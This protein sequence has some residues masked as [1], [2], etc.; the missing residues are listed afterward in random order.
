MA[1]MK[2][3]SV[4]APS[5]SSVSI[6]FLSSTALSSWAV[7]SVASRSSSVLTMP[8]TNRRASRSAINAAR[9]MSRTGT[10]SWVTKARTSLHGFLSKSGIAGTA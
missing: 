4:L 6:R 3:L 10:T 5:V 8:W 2:N 9:T 7:P 1:T